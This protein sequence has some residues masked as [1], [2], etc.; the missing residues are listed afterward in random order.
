MVSESRK[1]QVTT[2]LTRFN[3]Y[4]AIV[5]LLKVKEDDPPKQIEVCLMDMF[6]KPELDQMDA[7]SLML[8]SLLEI[9]NT[10]DG[11]TIASKT[12]SDIK[13]KHGL[14]PTLA[15]NL[16]RFFNWKKRKCHC[17]MEYILDAGKAVTCF[18]LTA[19]AN[20]C[21]NVYCQNCIVAFMEEKHHF[22][23]K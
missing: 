18:N 8:I 23:E 4:G 19:R 5:E 22:E 1:Q 20:P 14:T 12:L 6:T 15:Q 17:C 9:G 2:T 7:S 13:D 11:V 21:M 10:I 3:N 16:S